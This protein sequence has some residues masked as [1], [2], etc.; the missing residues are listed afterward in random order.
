MNYFSL[1]PKYDQ[2]MN[3]LANILKERG[4]LAEAESLLHKATTIR[5]PKMH[6]FFLQFG[7]RALQLQRVTTIFTVEL[8]K[9]TV[10]TRNIFTKYFLLDQTFLQHG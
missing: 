2:A 1:Y 9:Y 10:V 3:N 6:L 8:K 4:G 7:N 5:Y